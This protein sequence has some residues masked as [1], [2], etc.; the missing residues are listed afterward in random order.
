MIKSLNVIA[1]EL[2]REMS[3]AN[4]GEKEMDVSLQRSVSMHSTRNSDEQSEGLVFTARSTSLLE[5]VKK[6]FD[7]RRP[8]VENSEKDGSGNCQS[9]DSRSGSARTQT[10]RSSSS[11]LG[12]L[13]KL[14]AETDHQSKSSQNDENAVCDSKIIIRI[15]IDN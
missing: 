14:E 6:S 4:V 12:Q 1:V 5:D 10:S 13:R 9:R 11:L 7:E 2:S 3:S 8:S 15:E